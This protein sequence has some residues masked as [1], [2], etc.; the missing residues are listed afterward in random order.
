MTL[1]GSGAAAI[2]SRAT[3]ADGSGAPRLVREPAKVRSTARA[4]RREHGTLALVPTMGFLHEGHLRLV[5]RAR[6]LCGAVALSIFVNPTQFG[7]DED[8]ET[9]PRNLDRDLDLAA[10]R[11]VDLVF[12]PSPEAMYP[13]PP[14]ITVDAGPLADRLC[15]RSRP[16]H[17]GGVL[18]VV[19]KLLHLLQPDVG[20]FGRKDFQQLVLVRRMVR[21]L[22]L[23]VH[24]E[25][26]PIVRESGGL[27]MSSRNGY[28]SDA[29]REVARS[30][31][32]SL[33]RVRERFAAGERRADE[34]EELA[35]RTM[36]AAGAEVEYVRVVDPESLDRVGEAEADA[37]CAVAA[38][39]GT[40]RLID[41]A[42]LGGPS[43]LDQAAAPR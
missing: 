2:G 22:D 3:G 30:L 12:A 33:R 31:S 36:E 23:D 13:L 21:E 41:N 18:T 32:V 38:R 4:L 19:L 17:F 39:V 34:L 37:V 10:A 42:A 28:L 25:G 40:T 7:P 9:Y 11:G 35:R 1:E 6:E 24:I 5:D 27:A 26:A 29:E 8:F 15:G 20:V 43:S 14:T 16:G